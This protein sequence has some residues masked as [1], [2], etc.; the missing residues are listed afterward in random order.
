VDWEALAPVYH[1][2]IQERAL[3]EMLIDVANYAHVPNGPGVMLLAHEGFYSVDNRAGELG[4][5]YNRRAPLEGSTG[6]KIAQAYDSALYAARMLEAEF[7]GLRFDD[8]NC[9]VFVNDRLL[10]P[11]V[12]ETFET[13]RPELEAFFS[14]RWRSEIQLAWDS[15]PRGLFRVRVSTPAAATA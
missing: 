2:W 11:N 5:L 3:P 12:P 7:P 13:L 8:H 1:R 4:V 15:N 6:D 10:A 9:E 14:D